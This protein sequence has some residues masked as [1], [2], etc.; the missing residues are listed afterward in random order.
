LWWHAASSAAMHSGR[1][2]LERPKYHV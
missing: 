1:G 2:Y